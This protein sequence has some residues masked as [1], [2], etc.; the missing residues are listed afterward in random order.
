[1]PCALTLRCAI[2]MTCHR[3]RAA[4]A[5]VTSATHITRSCNIRTQQRRNSAV[6]NVLCLIN[7]AVWSFVVEC[8]RSHVCACVCREC[9]LSGSF[10]LVHNTAQRRSRSSIPSPTSRTNCEVG[11]VCC[12]LIV[13]VCVLRVLWDTLRSYSGI[14]LPL[15]FACKWLCNRQF[16]PTPKQRSAYCYHDTT[17]ATSLHNYLS[18]RGLFVFCVHIVTCRHESLR[19]REKGRQVHLVRSQ[20]RN[21]HA[22]S[23]LSRDTCTTI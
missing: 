3:Q 13:R 22:P 15:P 18:V 17:A 16:N 7:C 21:P 4:A 10:S 14:K 8:L 2:L 5:A 6:M 9:V 20:S 12:A 11:T 1:M 19:A 23:L